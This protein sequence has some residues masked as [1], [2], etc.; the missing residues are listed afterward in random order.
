MPI[1][2]MCETILSMDMEGC[3]IAQESNCLSAY[4]G[5]VDFNLHANSEGC[6]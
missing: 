1:E 5:V 6:L 4:I 3:N 2:I